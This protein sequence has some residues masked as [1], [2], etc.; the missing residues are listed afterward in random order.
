[1]ASIGIPPCESSNFDTLPSISS[2]TLLPFLSALD[3]EGRGFLIGSDL[4]LA[5]YAVGIEPPPSAVKLLLKRMEL[6]IAHDVEH[7]KILN[8]Q[9]QLFFTDH[10]VTLEE[11]EKS[12]TG[13]SERGLPIHPDGFD[14][15]RS[16][17]RYF[18]TGLAVWA[19]PG[20]NL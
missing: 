4:Y 18:W 8:T 15:S 13:F 11:L 9:I 19:T 2:S 7:L 10:D 16:Q 20:V 12:T 6:V 17:A 14:T 3:Q 5:I 1:M